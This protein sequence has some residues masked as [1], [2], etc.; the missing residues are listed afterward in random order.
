MRKMKRGRTAN[1]FVSLSL[2]G[3][4][5]GA[6]ARAAAPAGDANV[7]AVV[8]H[9]AAEFMD[10]PHAVGLSVGVV[11]GGRSHSYHFGTV[12][13]RHQQVANDRSI[14]AIASL[15]KTFT[16]TLLAQ[17]ELDGKLKL[18]DDVR[19]YLDGSYPNLAF[20]GQPI[21][22]YHLLNHRSG[23]PYILPNPPEASP[24]FKSD[25]PYPKR[26]DAIVAQPR[27]LLCRLAH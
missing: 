27:R 1:I 20:E 25:V 8:A 24:E 3:L 5:T 13:K 23:L 26:T 18:N 19:K 7:N 22:I 4:L 10:D 2:F 17:A 15:T 9:A 11:Q 14:Y 6:P 16:G 21:R 12:N